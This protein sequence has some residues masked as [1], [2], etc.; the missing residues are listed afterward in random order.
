MHQV[1]GFSSEKKMASVLTRSEHGYRLYNKVGTVRSRCIALDAAYM[2]K[3][4]NMQHGTGR[5]GMGAAELHTLP[6][7]RR[8]SR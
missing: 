5:C 6:E 8:L 2:V 1:Y 7:Q 4:A 3:L